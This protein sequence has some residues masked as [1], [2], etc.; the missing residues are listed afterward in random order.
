MKNPFEIVPLIV[1][2]LTGGVGLY[3]LRRFVCCKTATRHD[4]IEGLAVGAFVQFTVRV[5]GVS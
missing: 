5:T 3:V 1:A 4:F 2:S